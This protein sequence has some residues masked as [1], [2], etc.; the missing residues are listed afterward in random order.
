MKDNKVSI[1]WITINQWH[2]TEFVGWAGVF[3][4]F[5]VIH[6][7]EVKFIGHAAKGGLA[8]RLRAYRT[9]RGTWRTHKA[10]L[11]IYNSRLEVTM[12]I[13][14]LD[15]PPNRIHRIL[16]SMVAQ[17]KPPWNALDGHHR[18]F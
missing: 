5:R 11:E 15:M 7:G 18:V 8:P 3:G 6:N 4:L 14:I 16:K 9:P 12:Q 13:A 10:G 1:K 2:R 17:R